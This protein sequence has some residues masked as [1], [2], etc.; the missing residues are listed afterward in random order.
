MAYK[1]ELGAM[2]AANPFPYPLTIGFFYREKMRAI[3]RIAPDEPLDAILEIG[4]GQGGLTRLL[5]P[6]ATITNVDL[7]VSFARAPAN[8][9][10]RMR[11]VGGDA[12][13]LPFA[14][15][16]FDAVTMFDVLEHI[17]DHARAA[18]EARRVVRAGGVI[19]ASSPHTR[20]RYPYFRFLA[21][22]CPHEQELFAEWGHVRRGY[23]LEDL[24]ALMAL[25]RAEWSTFISPVTALAHDLSFSKLPLTIRRG[26]IAMLWPVTWVGYAMHDRHAAGTE[27]AVAWR[28]PA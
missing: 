21:P 15:G 10:P 24:D 13:R 22:V 23:T 3:H 5:Y 26:L 27:T 6:K 18:S 8:R 19:M 11:F 7:D 25:P 4:G 1:A 14:D 9:L 12:T 16:S 2:L 20:W 28:K 17:P